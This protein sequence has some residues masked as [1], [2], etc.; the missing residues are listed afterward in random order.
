MRCQKVRSVMLRF[1]STTEAVLAVRVAKTRAI[2]DESPSC[3][4]CG[5]KFGSMELHKSV[6][7]RWELGAT[8]HGTCGYCDQWRSSFLQASGVTCISAG[9]LWSTIA[10]YCVTTLNYNPSGATYGETHPEPNV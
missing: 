9:D 5:H 10:K 2:P 7:G 1:A 6:R 4:E 8:H 3:I